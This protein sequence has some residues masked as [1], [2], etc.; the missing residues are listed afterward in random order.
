MS[1]LLK[2]K[3]GSSSNSK[4]CKFKKSLYGLK[5]LPK[6]LFKR[7]LKTMKAL[8]YKQIYLD[9]TLFIKHKTREVTTLIVYVD[10]MVLTSD[11]HIK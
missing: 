6:L 4:V 3:C 2:S 9:H 8:G 10:D 5:Q 11:D 1:L 7:F